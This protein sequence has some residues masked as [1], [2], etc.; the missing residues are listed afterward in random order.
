MEKNDKNP[1][2]GSS[3]EDSLKEDGVLEETKDDALKIYIALQIRNALE[4]SN[5]TKT[6][7]ARR[8]STSRATVGRI[9]DPS[10]PSTT[11]T[12]LRKVVNALGKS[13]TLDIKS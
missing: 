7:L 3:F 8:M 9:L 5:I 12:T 1:C 2:I 11:L 13:I 4:E 6:E 10:N